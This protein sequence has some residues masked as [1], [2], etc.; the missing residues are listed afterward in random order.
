MTHIVASACPKIVNTPS[1]FILQMK[2]PQGIG[3]HQRQW[4]RELSH[5]AASVEEV[6]QTTLNRGKS[7]KNAVFSH[8]CVNSYGLERF[9]TAQHRLMCWEY[10]VNLFILQDCDA[11][12]IFNPFPPSVPIW[13]RLA[14]LL[15]LILEGIIKKF[16]MIV[17]TASR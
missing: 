3:W 17:A 16:P 11:F 7:S 13:H 9:S 1:L 14:K 2:R 6:A 15:I 8:F 10:G 4:A 5:P 12:K